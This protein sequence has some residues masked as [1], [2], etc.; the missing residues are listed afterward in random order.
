AAIRALDGTAI[1]GLVASAE[2]PA[3]GQAADAEVPRTLET[4]R[5][6]SLRQHLERAYPGLDPGARRPG[7]ATRG[8]S[9]VEF[10]RFTHP[11]D[12]DDET[13]VRLARRLDD[14][15]R[16][17]ESALLLAMHERDQAGSRTA[18][19]SGIARARK[20]GKRSRG[21]LGHMLLELAWRERSLGLEYRYRELV[22]E[23]M[24]VSPDDAIIEL[25][26]ADRVAED[27]YHWLG[28][29][30]IRDMLGRYP[31]SETLHHEL[32][33]RLRG[34]G[35]T[36]EALAVLQTS[37]S[38]AGRERTLVSGRIEALLDLGK[39]DAAAKLARR[40]AEAAPGLP[41]AHARLAHLEQAR[42]DAKAAQAALSKAI[43]LAPHD[44]LLHAERG[45]MLAR[46]GN[47][48]AAAASLRRSLQLRPQQ[49]DVRDLLATLDDGA[50]DDLFARYAVEL[51]KVGA[52]KT[53]AAWKGKSA[54][55]L[56]QRVAVHVHDN[57]LTDRLD[58]RIVR[59]LDE[60]GLRQQSVQAHSYDPAESYVEVK[61]ARV[62]RA[63]G[64]IEELGD[65][66]T[67]SLA[68]AG[69]RMYYD[70]RQVQ[71]R[72]SGL[73]VGD[74]LEV[75]FLHRDVAARNMFDEYF[76]D[77]VPLQGIEPRKRVE[78]VLEAPSDKAL[79]FNRKIK[80]TKR[81][82][83]ITVYRHVETNVPGIK[84][85][86]SMP[87]WTEFARFLHVSTYENWDDVGR[88]YWDLVAGQLVV[89]DKIREGVA[90]AIK[91]LPADAATADK[92]GAIY[93][94]V[95]RNTRY[96]GLEFGIH[97]YKPYR[98]TDIYS[99]RF[100]DCKDKASLLKVMLAEVGIDSHLVLVR[101]RD[102]GKLPTKP[103]SLSAFN[104]AIVYVPALD[105]FLDGT[106]E[107]SGPGE[108]PVNDQGASVLV[109][110][111]GKG[112]TFRTIPISPAL[113]NLRTTDQTVTLSPDGSAAVH[114]RSVVHGAG[115]SQLRFQFQ[116]EE[117]RRER[118]AKAFGD[119]FPGAEILDSQAPGIGNIL[120]P[121]EL[122]TKLNVPAWGKQTA[123]QMRFSV[124]GRD[125]R[126][127]ASLAPTAKRTH[128]LLLD[129]ATVERQ[130]IHYE[131][132]DGYRLARLPEGKTIETP[133]GRF[134]LT[135]TKTG[136]G[137]DVH[138]D[139]SLSK[140]RI[141]PAEYP[142]FRDFLRQV[143]ATLEQSFEVVKG[144]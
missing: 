7:P 124:M 34:Q 100:G 1:A 105:L 21:R 92:V 8:L 103:A 17:S 95:V 141:A 78:Y 70:Q 101:T 42:G 83:G 54:G 27:G 107:W 55:I 11:F 86:N 22:D 116:A 81:D 29:A 128:D 84:P 59:I 90:E 94:H 37:A 99:R 134:E 58:H 10:Y 15:V 138:S 114:Q 53:P 72:F 117:A 38:K 112:A 79:Y 75:A 140:Q 98:T 35:R 14:R 32:A 113:A 122:S 60:R 108:L 91:G 4:S 85:E 12:R 36:G 48:D 66:H 31:E 142:R 41:E 111:D 88:W 33:S 93:A 63:D 39:P 62:R 18:L 24:Q 135:V 126:L 121:A 30:W 47:K 131:L 82:D 133:V 50:D 118:L 25:A 64:T 104:H 57:G 143:D 5:P 13:P 56:H 44:A 76:G 106:A 119:T 120:V 69:Y 68:S 2:P 102:Q 80:R 132:P 49:P 9:L 96:V 139:L 71:V 40:A 123:G 97:G 46:A 67:V 87:G 45:R 20:E 129:T 137:A 23:A 65:T 130:T 127:A 26:L 61:R 28:L 43:A 77:M 52:A 19:V 3:P 125:S 109:V 73:R 89:D 16:S 115:A 110:Q 74:T 136:K 51:A 6:L 144:Q